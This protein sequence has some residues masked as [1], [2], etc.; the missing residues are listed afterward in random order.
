MKMWMLI[1]SYVD[2]YVEITKKSVIFKFY[3]LLYR[4]F[5]T[6]STGFST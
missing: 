2:N 4:E 6:V 3:H 5:S 1:T